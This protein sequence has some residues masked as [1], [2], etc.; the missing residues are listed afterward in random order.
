MGGAN[1]NVP[2][3]E[4]IVEPETE[5]P[6]ITR[7]C[8]GTASLVTE[9]PTPAMKCD[10]CGKK[11]PV[12]KWKEI[13]ELTFGPSFTQDAG[14][15]GEYDRS[16]LLVAK[17]GV[18]L[19]SL[20]EHGAFRS[21]LA[22]M[23]TK[24]A[25]ASGPDKAR[26]K[27]NALVKRHLSGTSEAPF[28]CSSVASGEVVFLQANADMLLTSNLAT[29]V[30]KLRGD[31][32]GLLLDLDALHSK[33]DM[34]RAAERKAILGADCSAEEELLRVIP[35]VKGRW[36]LANVVGGAVQQPEQ[37]APRR[38][39]PP[40]VAAAPPAAEGS[41]AALGEAH[42][43]R[44]AAEEA[45][46]A[47]KQQQDSGDAGGRGHGGGGGAQ[48]FGGGR[49]GHNNGRGGYG[50]GGGRGG[51]GGGYNNRGG[52]GGY[53]N[54]GGYGG[55]YNRGGYNGGSGRGGYN[56]RGGY[57]G[58][59]RYE[60]YYGGG[61]AVVGGGGFGPAAGRPIVMMGPGMV[62]PFPPAVQQPL[63]QQM[64][65]QQPQQLLQQVNLPMLGNGQ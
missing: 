3:V 38:E 46:G 28:R 49:G 54:R 56:G 44:I 32:S 58:Y 34:V 14:A 60:G 36:A 13:V 26:E 50:R 5:L 16:V 47:I 1:N 29:L 41:A 48:G 21:F 45:R 12:A 27:A 57:V 18:R 52:Y 8:D 55:G 40:A 43:R 59:G 17:M 35:S 22:D 15:G 19:S 10:T 62:A 11:L 37:E 53:H 6:C 24:M 33:G 4:P 7:D 51:G 63:P 9:T 30:A 20:L 61:P 39:Q 2:I 64:V 42:I 23:E 25:K 31:T 65:M